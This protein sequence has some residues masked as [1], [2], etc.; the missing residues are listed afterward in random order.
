MQ[1]VFGKSIAIKDNL[2]K[3]PSRSTK[4]KTSTTSKTPQHPEMKECYGCSTTKSAERDF[5][6]KSALCKTCSKKITTYY[7]P[8]H[9]ALAF[10]RLLQLTF[11]LCHYRSQSSLWHSLRL[12]ENIVTHYK[13][14]PID[15]GLDTILHTP[16]CHTVSQVIDLY[17]RMCLVIE[18]D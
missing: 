6:K 1:L 13:N 5:H 8:S 4:G 12:S 2:G 9:R 3:K 14:S 7:V 15:N 10:V 17:D 11:F 18:E 16:G